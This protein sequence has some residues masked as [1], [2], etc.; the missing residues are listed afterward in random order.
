MLAL[1]TRLTLTHGLIN[2]VHN[3]HVMKVELAQNVNM[4]GESF[5]Q[6]SSVEAVAFGSKQGQRKKFWGVWFLKIQ[7]VLTI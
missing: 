4:G 5:K 1:V 6:G 2:L 3:N 7:F